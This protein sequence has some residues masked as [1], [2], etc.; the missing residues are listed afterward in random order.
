MGCL[1]MKGKMKKSLI[2][3]I[4]CLFTKFIYSEPYR[5]ID[6]NIENISIEEV[7]KETSAYS[8]DIQLKLVKLAYENGG[9]LSGSSSTAL[10]EAV[11]MNKY[12]I[13]EYLLSLDDGKELIDV[14]HNMFA[15]P[16]FYALYNGNERITELLLMNGADPSL[17]TS[18]GDTMV[19]M[20]QNWSNE[21]S[22][23][24]D[25]CGEPLKKVILR[26]A[27]LFIL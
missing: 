27:I 14:K 20:L 6:N 15:R 7:L 23:F 18:Y 4:V 13:V 25:F 16:L 3:L 9:S 12:S 8:D 11:R 24:Y 1:F 17:T 10:I 2:F 22:G 5:A 19:E 26:F 21:G